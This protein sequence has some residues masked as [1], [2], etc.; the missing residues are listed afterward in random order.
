MFFENY[1]PATGPWL[2]ALEP[3]P[4]T[5]VLRMLG[6]QE[7]IVKYDATG[8]P[9]EILRATGNGVARMQL[10]DAKIVDGRGLPMPADKR[11]LAP[12]KDAAAKPTEAGAT[13]RKPDG[14]APA[15]R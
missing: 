3:D 4:T 5:H 2:M 10:I 14:G 1:S 8:V 6:S 12:P 7:A 15:P 11:A 13:P 9:T